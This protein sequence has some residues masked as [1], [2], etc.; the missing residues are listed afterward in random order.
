M[1]RFAVAVAVALI[2]LGSVTGL[3]GPHA[4]AEDATPAAQV[5]TQGI[6]YQPL[7]LV[8]GV[9]MAE[10]VD[11]EIARATLAPDFGFPFSADDPA[12]AMMI[13]ES[14]EITATVEDATWTISRGASVA[15][16]LAGTPT[17]NGVTDV[18][19]TIEPGETATFSAG[20][21]AY[22]PGSA[23]GELRNL[24]DEPAVT[25]VITYL[26]ASS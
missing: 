6:T 12:A 3:S 16:M 25:L 24:G 18:V 15:A 23:A 14:G 5:S 1:H 8:P 9:A 17:A 4:L 10:A 2:G 22:I 21:V 26:P 20:D 11:M 19:E 7:G 13:M